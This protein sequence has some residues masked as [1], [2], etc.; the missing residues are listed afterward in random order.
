MKHC[1][2][3]CHLSVMIVVWITLLSVLTGSRARAE[4]KTVRLLTIGNSFAENALTYLP[5]IV[6]SAGH[7]LVVGRANLGGCTL[8]RH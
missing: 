4:Q 1:S 3:K 5:Q 8:E 6:D 2:E 7:N